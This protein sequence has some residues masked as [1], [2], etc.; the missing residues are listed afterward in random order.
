MPGLAHFTEHMLFY[1]SEKYPAEDE[2]RWALGGTWR[3]KA[4][5]KTRSL[6]GGQG[7]SRRR[8]MQKKT[9]TG[10]VGGVEGVREGEPP[11]LS[12]PPCLSL[13]RH[14]PAQKRADALASSCGAGA[15]QVLYT[16]C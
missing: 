16:T 11:C 12:Q 15:L 1:S 7:V 13:G 9:S 3:C 2:Y 4:S 5:V 6:Q 10:V 8:S 14:V